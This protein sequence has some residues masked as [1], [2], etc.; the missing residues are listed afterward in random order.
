MP[1]ITIG[2]SATDGSADTGTTS[3]GST[4]PNNSSSRYPTN[5]LTVG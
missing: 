5:A 2:S 4:P 1:T 3:A